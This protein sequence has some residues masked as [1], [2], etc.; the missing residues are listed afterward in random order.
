MLLD[1]ESDLNLQDKEGKTALIWGKLLIY[2]DN[3]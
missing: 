3:L 1:E 2:F